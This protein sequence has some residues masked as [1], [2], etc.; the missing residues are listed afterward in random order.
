MN[1]APGIVNSAQDINGSPGLH[2]VISSVSMMKSVI[3]KA[4]NQ[5]TREEY[6]PEDNCACPCAQSEPWEWPSEFCTDPQSRVLA[7]QMPSSLG[8]GCHAR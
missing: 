5:K 1:T 7:S 2:F 3:G 4:G 8:E 6:S